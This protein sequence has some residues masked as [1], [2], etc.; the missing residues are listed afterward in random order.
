MKY[1]LF[2]FLFITNCAIA[3]VHGFIYTHVKFPGEFNPYNDVKPQK[4]AEGCSR[5]ILGLFGWGVSGVGDVAF[6]NGIRKIAIVDHS[7][8]SILQFGYLPAIYLNYC[9][10]VYGE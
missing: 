7:S 2:L 6:E 9:T 4:H 5:V 3:P 1:L 10:I 8:V